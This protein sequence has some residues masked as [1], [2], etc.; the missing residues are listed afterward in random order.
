MVTVYN[1][2]GTVDITIDIVGYYVQG[3]LYTYTGDGLR[4]SKTVGSTTSNFVYDVNASVPA[5]LSDG[6]NYY[7][8]G[9]IGPGGQQL[10][11]EQINESGTPAP[12]FLHHDRQGSTVATT[13]ATGQVLSTA[14]YD[15]YGNL[16]GSQTT[17]PLGYDGAYTDAETGL[18]YLI[19]RYYDPTTGQFL[20][21]DPLVAATGQPYAYANG[22][23]VSNSD[24]TGLSFDPGAG[25][26][27]IVNIGRGASFGL[28]DRIANLFSSGAS[29][30]VAQNG[31]DQFIGAAAA[32]L[33]LGTTPAAD[34]DA[35]NPLEDVPYSAKVEAQ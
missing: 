9:P 12:I 8:Y 16:I 34:V 30:T 1:A 17:T 33:V 18:L 19:D 6:T 29:C 10:P 24:P 7:I 27:A 2:L 13:S 32:S 4:S 3:A 15:P 14:G 23:P 35:A 25:A 20:S 11:I 26:N 22:N 28:T 21:V 31:V 5:V